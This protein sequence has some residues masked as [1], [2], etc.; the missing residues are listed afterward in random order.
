MKY[1]LIALALAALCVPAFAQGGNENA[2]LFVTFTTPTPDNG[3]VVNRVDPA[4]FEAFTAYLGVTDLSVGMTGINFMV[5][6]T[7]GVSLFYSFTNLLPGNLAIGSWDTGISLASTQCIGEDVS[8][9]YMDPVIFAKVDMVYSSGTGD[10]IFLDH[11]VDA[12]WLTNC[13]AP[14]VVDLFCVWTNGGIWKDPEPA[15]VGCN[16]NTPA[17]AQTWGS[18]KALYK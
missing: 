5:S 16:S 4:P 18:I 17:E 1:V 8:R 12:R 11:P 9:T 14:A 6:I 3:S 10:V 15:D 13:D 2:K 7:P